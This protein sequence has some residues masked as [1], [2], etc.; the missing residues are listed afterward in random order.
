MTRRALIIASQTHGLRG[1]DN[2][3]AEIGGFLEA[4]AFACRMLRGA[5]A[6]RAGIHAGLKRLVSETLVGDTV[7]LYYSG[8]GA[9]ISN[10]QH[11][12]DRPHEP[13]AYHCIIPA[14]HTATDFRAIFS[15]ELSAYIAALSLR[16]RN[17]TVVL[18][19]C[20]AETILKG[21]RLVSK[22]IPLPWSSAVAEHRDWLRAQGVDLHARAEYVES[23]PHVIRLVACA[24]SQSAFERL[25]EDGSACG[26]LTEALVGTLA[27]QPDRGIAWQAILQ[28]VRA[29]VSARRPG[30]EPQLLGP[31]ARQLFE[32][33]EEPIGDVLTFD[34]R[35]GQPSLS[36]GSLHGV[37]LGS[38]YFLMPMNANHPDRGLALADVEVIEVRSDRALISFADPLQAY[39]LRP[40]LRAFLYR[41][42]RTRHSIRLDLPAGELRDRVMALLDASA[43]VCC[44]DG[45][46]NRPIA[47]IYPESANTVIAGVR[48]V[49]ERL[50]ISDDH[51][52]DRGIG[53]P[54]SIHDDSSLLIS[55]VEQIARAYDLLRGNEPG[56]ESRLS[57][58]PTLRWGHLVDGRPVDLPREACSL[59]EG[60]RIYVRITSH[61]PAPVFVSLLGV[62]INRSISLL[63]TSEPAGVELRTQETYTLGQD[64]IGQLFAVPLTWP[65]AIRRDG[66]RPMAIVAVITDT[67]VDLRSLES[68][69]STTTATSRGSTAGFC[70]SIDE[71]LPVNT[72][73]RTK[74]FDLDSGSAVQ[75]RSLRIL[76][77]F[78]LNPL[79]AKNEHDRKVNT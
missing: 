12:P 43:W 64:D 27:D 62:G 51:H 44:A 1:V 69:A 46:T 71:V 23:N 40:G 52:H 26:L 60:D 67:P 55:Q 39:S 31:I 5:A 9:R 58:A 57:P 32:T 17:I 19:C 65:Q 2:D 14:D 18:D 8:H 50:L 37:T 35:D 21:D 47:T 74:N 45:S 11:R 33:A 4:R 66:P 72:H 73:R 7:F 53:V 70:R 29:R 56:G 68:S 36:G 75:V 6:D 30:Q 63:S 28:A 61:S 54:W 13:R 22:S 10:P 42:T 16:T 79:L 48:P 3:A 25:R 34:K 77:R 20:H 41:P 15:A 76:I 24:D 59:H 49:I 78:Q 38:R